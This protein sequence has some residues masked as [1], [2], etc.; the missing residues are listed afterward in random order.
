MMSA[1]PNTVPRPEI[2]HRSGSLVATLAAMLGFALVALLGVLTRPPLPIDETRYLAVAWEMHLSGNWIVPH[3]NGEIY[4]HKPPL[5]FWLI[6]LVWAVT[7]VSET[8]ARLVGPAFGVAT[9]GATALLARRLARPIRPR[10]VGRRWRSP[11]LPS[12]PPMPA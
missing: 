3:L 4:A 7:G 5:L 1:D 11:A 6:N 10:A 8:A 9:I 12:S 2:S